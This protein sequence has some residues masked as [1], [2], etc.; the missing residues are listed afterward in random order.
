MEEKKLISKDQLKTYFENGKRPTENQFS[1]LIDALKHKGD[2]LTN[3][4]AVMIA[5]SLESIDTEYITYSGN[6]IDDQKFLMAIHSDEKEDQIITLI[7][8]PEGQKKLYFLGN[9]P[10]TIRAK[11]FPTGGLEQNEYYYAS[12]QL[13]EYSNTTRLFGGNLPKIYDGFE[14]GTLEAKNLSVQ[15]GKMNLGQR[16]DVI[17]ANIRFVNTTGSPVQYSTQALY[18]SHV[19]TDKDIVTD[20]YSIWNYFALYFRADLRK[21]D[22]SIECNIYN[23][24]N[25]TLLMTII[26]NAG[27]NNK[28]IPAS[29]AIREIKNIR[30]E[31]RYAVK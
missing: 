29:E 5:N 28:N 31:C 25:G 24:D 20:H 18:W 11:E 17:N 1:D 12:C 2:A 8:T 22:Q 14:F 6:N 15:V 4:E 30:I 16:I 3:R 19:Y 26:L 10:Y 9:A 21:I 23:E 7:N 27:Q 13:G